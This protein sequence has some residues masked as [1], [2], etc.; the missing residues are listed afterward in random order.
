MARAVD[1]QDFA[2]KSFLEFP[3]KIFHPVQDPFPGRASENDA[4]GLG[5]PHKRES[6]ADERGGPTQVPPQ[7]GTPPWHLGHNRRQFYL[8]PRV[9]SQS[10]HGLSFRWHR[11]DVSPLTGM[12]RWLRKTITEG[13]P[14][15]R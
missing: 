9:G 2:P 12:A 7:H 1:A 10:Q 4:P 6:G 3:A 11:G 14:Q 8:A 5:Q 13:T 15:R